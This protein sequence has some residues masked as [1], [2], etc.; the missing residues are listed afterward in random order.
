MFISSRVIS[1]VICVASEI[2]WS[3]PRTGHSVLRSPR[4]KMLGAYFSSKHSAQECNYDIYDK[5]LLAIIN[6]LDEWR[7]SFQAPTSRLSQITGT[8]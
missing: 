7:L 1:H 8:S 3:M 2:T 5:E 4:W 6:A